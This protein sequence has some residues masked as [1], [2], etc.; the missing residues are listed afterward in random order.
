MTTNERNAS[1]WNTV[2][3]SNKKLRL[4]D[5]TIHWKLAYQIMNILQMYSEP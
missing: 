4:L 5:E 1:V 3:S 2:F